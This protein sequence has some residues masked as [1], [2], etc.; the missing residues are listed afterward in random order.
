[1]QGRT[2]RFLDQKR[3]SCHDVTSDWPGAEG[4]R[5]GPGPGAD[6]GSQSEAPRQERGGAAGVRESSSLHYIKSEAGST[7]VK[8]GKAAGGSSDDH[9][10][11]P[12]ILSHQSVWGGM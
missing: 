2:R 10:C 5:A 1:M 9:A 4:R 8:P 6:P 11:R 7:L 12:A 3:T